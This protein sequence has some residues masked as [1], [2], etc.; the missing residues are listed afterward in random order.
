MSTLQNA[1]LDEATDAFLTRLAALADHRIIDCLHTDYGIEVAM[2][3]FLPLGADTNASVYKAEA[4]NQLSYFV[5]LKRGHDHD[6]SLY[7]C[8]V[9]TEYRNST[10]HSSC[11]ND[12]RSTNPAH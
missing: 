4:Q 1:R 3:T 7:H 5:K 6:I 10:D 9:I 2:L 12:P 8:R 11:Q